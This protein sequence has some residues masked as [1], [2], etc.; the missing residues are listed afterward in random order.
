MI[1]A[2]YP[3]PKRD[4]AIST[5]RHTHVPHSLLFVC[6]SAGENRRVYIQRSTSPRGCT[7]SHIQ[8]ASTVALLPHITPKE[9]EKKIGLTSRRTSGRGRGARRCIFLGGGTWLWART[10][11]FRGNAEMLTLDAR[12]GGDVHGAAA[13]FLRLRIC[14]C[15]D[16]YCRKMQWCGVVRE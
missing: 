6:V 15:A 10:K 11:N 12:G 14:V 9:K 7:R 13:H 4:P 3:P 8:Q 5:T 1:H 2:L 16:V